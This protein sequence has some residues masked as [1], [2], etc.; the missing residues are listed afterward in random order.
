LYAVP[1]E[2]KA[3]LTLTLWEERVHS[4][5]EVMPGVGG[6]RLRRRESCLPARPAREPSTPCAV[7]LVVLIAHSRCSA[8]RMSGREKKVS[9]FP[10]SDC[11]LR[12]ACLRGHG[13]CDL[14][15]MWWVT[16]LTIFMHCATRAC[17]FRYVQM[18]IDLAWARALALLSFACGSDQCRCLASDTLSAP[19]SSS[20]ACGRRVRY[21]N[22]RL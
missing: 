1:L 16:I 18:A 15:R 22:S 3:T 12:R 7:A 5:A 10:L 8:M 11:H 6:E 9:C 2:G 21:R 14:G 19:E 4:M 17:E 20:R 13:R